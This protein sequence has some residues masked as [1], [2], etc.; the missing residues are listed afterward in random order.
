MSESEQSQQADAKGASDTNG[1]NGGDLAERL[2]ALDNEADVRAAAGLLEETLLSGDDSQEAYS[3]A[4]DFVELV[5]VRL[6]DKKRVRRVLQQ[7]NA[8]HPGVSSLLDLEAD[9]LVRAGDHPTRPTL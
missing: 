4:S 3:L 7:L 1:T 5:E 9:F 6:H 2:G 8:K